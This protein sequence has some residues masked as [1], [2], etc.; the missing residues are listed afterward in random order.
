MADITRTCQECS[1]QFTFAI[2]P[3][4]GR[5]YCCDDCASAARSRQALQWR[6]RTKSGHSA[7]EGCGLLSGKHHN[8]GLCRKC[9]S[10]Q[11][12][13]TS[14]Q[15]MR[16]LK[17]FTHLPP[18]L[19]SV[20]PD[21]L[22]V[23]AECGRDH[24]YTPAFGEGTKVQRYCSRQCQKR[25]SDRTRTRARRAATRT[26]KCERVDYNAVFDRDGWKCG[27]CGVKTLRSKRGTMHDRAPVLDHIIPLSKGGDHTYKNVQCACNSCNSAKGADLIGQL[28]LFG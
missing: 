16:V 7:C 12:R 2:S 27:L 22:I 13:I 3:G 26:D 1:N 18:R 9:M 25:D 15:R 28:R 10:E 11:Q 17:G 21:R 14:A 19:V 6:R 8:K 23:C 20:R 5:V 4:A 24:V